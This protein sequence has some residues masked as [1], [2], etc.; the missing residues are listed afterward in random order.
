[1]LT[2]GWRRGAEIT[3]GRVVFLFVRLSSI[4]CGGV[5]ITVLALCGAS[6]PTSAAFI[7]VLFCA[8]GLPGDIHIAR[9]HA[10]SFCR[11]RR[12][13]KKRT[14]LLVCSYIKEAAFLRSGFQLKPLF[15]ARIPTVE[16]RLVRK[17]VLTL[18]C[19]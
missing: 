2:G 15:V 10:T 9:V 12:E 19:T 6:I 18:L 8:C 7:F 11:P 16:P 1:M 3:P 4:S 14:F 17:G 5:A 13:E